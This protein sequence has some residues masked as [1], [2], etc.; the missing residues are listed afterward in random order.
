MTDAEAINLAN[1]A[2]G[3]AGVDVSN[4]KEPT[5]TLEGTTWRLFY[6]LRPPGRPGGH[7]TVTV[8]PSGQTRLI[9]GR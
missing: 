2:A 9:P 6:D 4:Y 7:F 1:M 5:V 8:D 3:A